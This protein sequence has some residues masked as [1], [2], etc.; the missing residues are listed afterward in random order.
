ML[1]DIAG[2]KGVDA[3]PAHYRITVDDLESALARQKVGLG[4]GDVVFVRT[5]TLRYWG[6]TGSDHEKLKEYDSAGLSL[7]GAKWLVEQKGA[8]MVG[9]DTSGLEAWPAPEGS[10]SFMPVHEYLLIEQG[11]HIAE[12]H[13]LEDLARD[14]VYE[15]AYIAL[16]N[17]IKGATAGFT[18]RPVAIR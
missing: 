17:K 18:M 4:P 15:F 1:L 7:A 16:V 6:K 8:I 3:L 14:Q 13:F 2:L 9:S 11:V 10:T 5:G 12:F